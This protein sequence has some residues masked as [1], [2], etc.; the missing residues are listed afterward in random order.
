MTDKKS[1]RKEKRKK[2]RWWGKK[3][4]DVSVWWCGEEADEVGGVCGC[5]E[6]DGVWVCVL[7]VVRNE[8]NGGRLRSIGGAPPRRKYSEPICG[9]V[10]PMPPTGKE[11][12]S[13][14]GEGACVGMCVGGKLVCAKTGLVE[15]VGW[16]ETGKKKW[17][18]DM[19]MQKKRRG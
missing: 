19:A 8:G 6:R 14:G 7:I 16:R 10:W 4:C 5:G 18:K 15:D 1:G 9:G 12:E 2:K 17:S 13:G 3:T 11:R